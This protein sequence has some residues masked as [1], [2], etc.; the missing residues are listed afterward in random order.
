QDRFEAPLAAEEHGGPLVSHHE[1]RTLA[2]FAED[3]GMGN[4]GARSD[5]PIDSADVVAGLIQTHFFKVDSAPAK[6]GAF[7]TG[8][9]TAHRSQGK[10]FEL[11][12]KKP[13]SQQ[14]GE[15]AVG[16]GSIVIIE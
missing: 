10:E 2:F 4:L 3:L 6:T 9:Q 12:C 5:P 1:N 14:L 16:S 11:L 15:I 13:Q 8:Q 7:T